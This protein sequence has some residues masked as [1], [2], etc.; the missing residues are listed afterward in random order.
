MK[1]RKQ[2][3][4]TTAAA[5]EVVTN[6]GPAALAT[7][8]ERVRARLFLVVDGTAEQAAQAVD[9]G[10]MGEALVH[11]MDAEECLRRARCAGA[12]VEELA[13]RAEKLAELRAAIE[14]I[15]G[16]TA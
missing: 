10:T 15:R 16:I 1:P 7:T 8:C 12:T 2:H 6:P 5:V 3:Q 9:A 4:I 14:A 13:P 11:L